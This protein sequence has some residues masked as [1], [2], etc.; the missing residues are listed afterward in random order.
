MSRKFKKIPS[1][2]SLRHSSSS[3]S[4]G[5]HLLGNLEKCPFQLE[6]LNISA[7]SRFLRLPLTSQ[8]QSLCVVVVV[9]ES[10]SRF[11]LTDLNPFDSALNDHLRPHT[12]P[13]TCQMIFSN[14]N[15]HLRTCEIRKVL[16]L[17]LLPAPSF[18]KCV[19]RHTALEFIPS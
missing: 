12:V 16:A 17:L 15:L 2:T 5:H 1:L 6:I 9:V 14:I 13:T 7:I 8:T 10:V 19:Q 11:S 3:S 4:F 18:N